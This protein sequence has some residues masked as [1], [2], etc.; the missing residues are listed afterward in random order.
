MKDGRGGGGGLSHPRAGGR[1]VGG[2]VR[3]S[4]H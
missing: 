1:G 4:Y 2:G 3:K